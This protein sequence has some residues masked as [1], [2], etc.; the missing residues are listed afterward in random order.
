VSHRYGFRVPIYIPDSCCRVQELLVR[1]AYEEAWGTLKLAADSGKSQAS[2]L[3]G[4]LL[5]RGI[6]SGTPDLI[7]A[8]RYLTAAAQR[9]D[10]YGQYGMAWL[11][12]ASGNDRDVFEWMGKSAGQLFLPAI[13]DTGRLAISGTRVHEPD[14]RTALRACWM[15][16][17]RGYLS[18]APTLSA[19]VKS[20]AVPFWARSLC[21]AW[22]IVCL[23]MM[24]Y[25]WS[26]RIY[27]VK[28]HY[29]F[30]KPALVPA[31]R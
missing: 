1:G 24:L 27:S 2:A 4:Y 5:L 30:T 15:A 12:Y 17:R 26:F 18:L 22:L 25:G 11:E 31:L 21:L 6:V 3:W 7:E 29:H 9:A 8:R 10:P 19:I 16:F 20:N 13:A 14:A 23:P 28:S